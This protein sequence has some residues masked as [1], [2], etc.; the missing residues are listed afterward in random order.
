VP[1]ILIVE[2]DFSIRQVI[3][4]VLEE[5]GYRTASTANG[6]EA[7]AY[8]ELRHQ[9]RRQLP[10]LILTDL[11][12]PYM[13]GRTLLEALTQTPA[14][15]AIPVLVMT[16][17]PELAVGLPP[18]SAVLEKPLVDLKLLLDLVRSLLPTSGTFST[19]G[20]RDWK[21]GPRT[22]PY[23]G[24]V[25]GPDGVDTLRGRPAASDP[26]VAEGGDTETR[27]IR[28]KK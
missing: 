22:R 11:A 2:D 17:D 8:L 14:L 28:P 21:E 6:R 1:T 25:A 9:V 16:G 27:K 5:E 19:A 10:G 26:S 20:S 15:A 4:E 7:L 18:V 24:P 12:M 13:D 23:G 3:A